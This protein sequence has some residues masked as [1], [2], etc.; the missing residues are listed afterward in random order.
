M[1]VISELITKLGFAVDKQAAD[2]ALAK[3]AQLEQAAQKLQIKLSKPLAGFL[4][5]N[6]QYA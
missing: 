4:A 3:Y 6:P 5:S 2:Q 1:T